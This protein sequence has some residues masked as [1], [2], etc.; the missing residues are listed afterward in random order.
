MGH[1]SIL[2]LCLAGFAAS[3]NAAAPDSSA[4]RPTGSVRFTGYIEAG[5]TLNPTTP[6][7]GVNFGHL[8]TDRANQ[9]VLNQFALAAERDPDPAATRLDLGFRLAG[10]YGFDSQFTHSIGLG[11]QPGTSRNAFDLREASLLAHAPVLTRRGLEVRIGLFETPLGYESSDPTRDVFYSKSY[12]FNFGLPRKHLGVL[13]TTHV[14][15]G[16]DLFLG[17]TTGV[18]TTAADGGGYND[19]QPHILGGFG[20]T[21]GRVAVRALTH[22]GPEDPPSVLLAGVAPHAQLR[23]LNDVVVSWKVS[24]RLTSV[25]ELN[26]VRDDGLKAEGGGV[27]E[28]LTWRLSPIVAASLRAEVWRDAQGRFVAGYPG[29]LDYINAE[30]GRPNGSYAGGPATYGALTLGLSVTPAHLPWLIHGLT[31]R[32]E[33]RYDRALGGG[34][35]F[36]SSPGTSRDQATVG[37]DVVVPLTFQRAAGDATREADAWDPR[38]ASRSDG[39]RA[40]LPEA[41]AT[42]PTLPGRRDAPVA[43]TVVALRGPGVLEPLALDEVSGFAP[44]V[45]IERMATG[46]ATAAISIRGLGGSD[47]EMGHTPGVGLVVDDVPIGAVLGQLLD[48]FDLAEI[49]VRRGPQGVEA[50]RDGLGGVIDVHR[51]RPTRRWGLDLDYGLQQGYHADSQKLLFNMPVGG[52]AGL[53]VSASHQRRGGYLNNIYTGDGLYGRDE[54]TTGNLQFDWTA[55]PALDVDFGLTLTHQD[56]AGAPVALG[57]TLAARLL[58]PMLQAAHPGLRFNAYGSP[59][60]GG[61]TTPLGAF[62]VANDYADRDSLVAQVYSLGL[63]WASP[64]GR[65]RSITAYIREHDDTRRDLDGGCGVSDLG[66]RPCPMLANPLAGVL[67]VAWPRTY[68][69]FTEDLRLTR[70]FGERVSLAAGLFYHHHDAATLQR[71]SEET[72]SRSAFADLTLAL[73]RKLSV[74]GGLRYVA[75]QTDYRLGVAATQTSGRVASDHVLTKFTLDYRLSDDARVYAD[76]ATGFRPGGLPADADPTTTHSTYGP[77]T[78]T[79]YEIGAKTRF[80]RDRLTVNLAGFVNEVSGHQLAEVVTTPGYG[81]GFNTYI[82][83]L[84]KARIKG[85]ELEVGYRPALVPDLTLAGSGGWQDARI[86]D[87]GV[88]GVEVPAGLTAGP[89]GSTYDLTGTSLQRAPR[90]NVSLRADYVRRVGPGLIDVNL[91]YRWTDRLVLGDLAGQPDYRPAVGLVDLSVS[92]SQGFYRLVVSARNLTN[93]VYP[94]AAT[95]AL[96]THSWGDPRTVTVELQA[97]F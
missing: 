60:I 77:E 65:L 9:A 46:P 76:R 94:G 20:L 71:S 78:D 26:Y 28:Y 4:D 1:F 23:Y 19:Q 13:T 35:P 14:G 88:P 36:G 52:V 47:L 6:D 18:N 95:P 48:S 15:R 25:T 87:G 3:A 33:I 31:V 40:A 34:K 70:D 91:G 45:D 41:I 85:V 80:L 55:T 74:S 27:A 11:D 84:P 10:A 58:G 7:N 21:L 12:I 92:Y 5:A 93:D 72:L 64:I 68:D 81:P 56:G 67:H 2:G 37:V 96:F 63:T 53:K 32:P 90:F 83:N 42:G 54:V 39:A 89:P 8:F 49:E 24:E 44:N 66:G 61:L 38:E 16:V 22:I 82:V 86:V 57:D 50:G 59:Y 17:Y 73:T 75:E 62:Q 30:E 43:T 97:R 69:Q 51:T 29:N 79:T